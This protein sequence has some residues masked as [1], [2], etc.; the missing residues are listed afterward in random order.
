MVGELTLDCDVLTVPGADLR[1]VTYT[2]TAGGTDAGETCS[3]SPAA[4]T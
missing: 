1:P 2:T 3:G 4:M